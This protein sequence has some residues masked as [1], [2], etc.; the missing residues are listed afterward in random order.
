MNRTRLLLAGTAIGAMLAATVIASPPA[1]ADVVSGCEDTV[2]LMPFQSTRRAICDGVRRPDGSW[3]RAR[4]HYTPTHYVPRRVNCTSSRYSSSC[5][6]TGGYWVD[7][8]EASS[9]TY[10]V[11]DY[12]VLPTEPGHLVNNER[13]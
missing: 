11:F 3:L 6:E 8:R 12:N 1:N 2:W 4:V 5:T 13:Y 7:Y 10:I 9:D